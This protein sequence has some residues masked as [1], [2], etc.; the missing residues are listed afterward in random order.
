METTANALLLNLWGYQLNLMTVMILAVLAGIIYMFIRIQQSERLDFAD[1]I[2]K[3]GRKVS[4][5]KVLQLLSGVASTW[6]IIK[7]GLQGTLTAEIFGIYL[8]YTA[9]IEGFSK[10][11]S[12]KYN[13]TET[14][15]R[16]AAP[17]SEITP[18]QLLDTAV[19]GDG[20]VETTV[21]A[22]IDETGAVKS[23][24]KKVKKG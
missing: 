9:S 22:N 5:T 10:F 1:M 16:D 13:Y 18:E 4:G 15:V 17:T 8:A 21:T 23:V 12:A 3:D 19:T 7:M 11:I 20:P 24:Q 6:I 14:S 2:T